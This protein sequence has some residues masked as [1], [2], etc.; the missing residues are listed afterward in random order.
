MSEMYCAYFALTVFWHHMIADIS[1]FLVEI[2][3]SEISLNLL[4]LN[5]VFIP[6]SSTLKYANVINICFK[7]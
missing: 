6:L 4:M 5:L 7:Q 2:T 1:I 3:K